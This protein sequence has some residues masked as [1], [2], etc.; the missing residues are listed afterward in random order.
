[1]DRSTS[2]GQRVALG[3]LPAIPINQIP[4]IKGVPKPSNDVFKK[5]TALLV[6]PPS[7]PPQPVYDQSSTSV[8]TIT[9]QLSGRVSL[10]ATHD[11][12]LEP[13]INQEIE[14]ENL[15][16]QQTPKICHKRFRYHEELGRGVWSSVLR[17]TEIPDVASL[18][19][20]P[21][22]SP[23][24]DVECMFLHTFAVKK[25]SRRDACE[26]LQHEARILSYLHK[27]PDAMSFLVP[28]HG[29]CPADNSLV[30][31][32]LPINLETY[33]KTA[34]Q[35]PSTS[36]TIYDPVIGREE[37][38]NAARNLVSGLA[39]LHQND[40]IHGDIKPSN[41]LLRFDGNGKMIPL[42]CDFSSSRLQ[43][44]TATPGKCEQITA[45]TTEYASPE[46]LEALRLNGATP[47]VATTASD[48]F[49]LAVTLLTAATGQSP[50][51][52]L[53]MQCQKLAMAKEGLP[54]E[55][56]RSGEQASRVM[57]GK[58]VDKYLWTSLTKNAENRCGARLWLE[59]IGESV[60]S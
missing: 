15:T 53:R 33:T 40:C 54:L 28:F 17:A 1:M 55:Y 2:L 35:K 21:P 52:G 5:S 31:D 4:R 45:V 20:S 46:L 47:A 8:D 36:K 18:Q 3:G 44:A 9:A 57:K 26:I 58:L 13:R 42:Y 59:K 51:A 12:A 48:V 56:A 14:Q 19:L 16:L 27:N 60:T 23:K 22:A 38:S 43:C 30:L 32:A 37:W 34:A 41:V 50:Y 39:F 7:T 25:P 24:N 29:L 11:E 6:T 49:A 10:E